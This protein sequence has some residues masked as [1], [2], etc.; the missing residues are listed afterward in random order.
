MGLDHEDQWFLT[1]NRPCFLGA[2]KFH[3]YQTVK[4]KKEYVCRRLSTLKY[5]LRPLGHFPRGLVYKLYNIILC[6]Y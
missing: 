1:K 3:G 5:F 4:L 6:K 2:V